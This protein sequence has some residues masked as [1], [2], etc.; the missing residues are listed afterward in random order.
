MD[1]YDSVVESWTLIFP[2]GGIPSECITF[3]IGSRGKHSTRIIA[4]DSIHLEHQVEIFE[5]DCD[6]QTTVS[7]QA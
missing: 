2:Q 1:K 6:E 4:R 7:S 5:R 3:H